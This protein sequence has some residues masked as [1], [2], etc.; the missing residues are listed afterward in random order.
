MMKFMKTNNVMFYAWGRSDNND[1][2][3]VRNKVLKNL[4]FEALPEFLDQQNHDPVV[5]QK[6]RAYKANV[7]KENR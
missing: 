3:H 7:E 6:R 5:Q 2:Q 4:N 1:I